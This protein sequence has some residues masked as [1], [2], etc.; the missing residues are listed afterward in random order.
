MKW[1][2][3]VVSYLK[4]RR[5]LGYE[6]VIEGRSLHQFA[7][8]AEEQHVVPPL[9]LSHA[10]NWANLASS[11]SSIAIARRLSLLRSF[12]RYLKTIWPDTPI[13]PTKLVGPTHRRLPPYIFSEIEVVRLM[14]A[15]KTLAPTSA[16]RAITIRTLIGLLAAT[17]IRPGEAIRLNRQAVDLTNAEF[18]IFQSKGWSQRFVPLTTSTVD[19]LRI[20]ERIR[21]RQ[22]PSSPSDAFFLLTESRPLDIRSADY[23]FGLLRKMVGLVDSING[24]NPRLYDLRHTFVCRRVLKWYEAGE[25][26]D[27]LM[28]HLSR[29]LGHKKVSDTYWYLSAI[30]ELMA[31]TAKRFASPYCAGDEQ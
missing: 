26:V 10:L 22:V 9:L 25:N 6:L 19:A 21:A 12:F 28:P 24:R 11:K 18:T 20:Y 7:L 30:P 17:G 27:A 14:N 1:S 31:C 13:I 5:E 15:T 2:S 16:L 4:Q 29:Y 3:C 23:A 8:F